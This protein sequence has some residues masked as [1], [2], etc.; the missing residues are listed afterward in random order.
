MLIYLAALD[1]VPA[2]LGEAAALD[3]ANRLQRWWR[4][5]VPLVAPTTAFLLVT[6]MVGAFQ[7]FA[8]VYILTD[9][10]PGTATTVWVHQIYTTAMRDFAFGRASA[11]AVI[12][13]LLLAG[14]AYLSGRRRGPTVQ[15]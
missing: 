13:A 2:S 3:G 7:V 10:G 6:G 4:V 12:L 15:Y 11:M 5:T 9:G 1:A 14:A 8:Q